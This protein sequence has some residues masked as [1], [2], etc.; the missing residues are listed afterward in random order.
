MAAIAIITGRNLGRAIRWQLVC[1]TLVFYTRSEYFGSSDFFEWFHALLG[2]VTGFIGF[3][4]AAMRS[5]AV[6]PSAVISKIFQ[7]VFNRA[8]HLRITVLRCYSLF[9]STMFPELRHNIHG[10]AI[11]KSAGSFTI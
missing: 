5:C 6:Q 4:A 10:F 8:I 2:R 1:R 11:I 7:Y 9:P 3:S